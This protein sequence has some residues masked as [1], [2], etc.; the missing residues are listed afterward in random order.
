[1]LLGMAE[2]LN[3]RDGRGKGLQVTT[4]HY[5]VFGDNKDRKNYHRKI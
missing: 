4:R 5:I 2:A 3:E 1:M